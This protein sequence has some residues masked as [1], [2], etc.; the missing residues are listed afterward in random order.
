MKN[1]IKKGEFNKIFFK[2]EI[3]PFGIPLKIIYS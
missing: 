2:K 3:A 1:D